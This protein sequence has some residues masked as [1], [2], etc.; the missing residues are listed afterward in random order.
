MK[1]PLVSIVVALVIVVATA[2]TLSRN[3]IGT[4]WPTPDHVTYCGRT[5]QRGTHGLSRAEID[6]LESKTA[7]PGDAP[8]PA[9]TV[10]RFPPIVGPPML[11]AVTPLARR[12]GFGLPCSMG[13]YLK[14][15]ADAYTAYGLSGG[16]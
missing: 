3:G 10:G 12:Q 14:T 5:Y 2:V 8:Y 16:P 9:V 4:W 7:L 11:A 15:G 1:Q 6:K 13:V